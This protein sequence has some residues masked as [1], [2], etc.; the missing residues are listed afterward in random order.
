VRH[1]AD[2]EVTRAYHEELGPGERSVLWSWIGFTG[3]FAAVRAITHAIRRG[4]GPFRNVSVGGV[5]LHHYMWGIGLVSAVGA[6]AVAGDDRDRR[7]PLV[8]LTYGAGLALIV[9]E[10][11]LLLDL[12]DV[13]WQRAGRVSVDLGVGTV[14]I[15]GTL[16]RAAP[17]IGRL[18]A[19]RLQSPAPP[20]TAATSASGTSASASR[21]GS[22]VAPA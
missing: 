17:I 3:T 11:A 2:S 18:V 4:G 13:Y 15:G 7:H 19:N 21:A 1:A 5:H 6:V 8:G 12:K 9:D 20:S 14:A 10:F 16:L 22:T